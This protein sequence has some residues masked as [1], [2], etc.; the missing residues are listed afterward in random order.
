M[1]IEVI[2][3]EGLKRELTIE[4]PA[5]V[6]DKTY[7]KI[8]DDF[9]R[10]AKIKGFRPGKVPINV[11]R[12]RFKNEVT[13]ELIEQL[14]GQYYDKAVQEK[15]LQP[16]GD[17]VLSSVDVDEGKPFKFTVGIEV[18][19]QIDVVKYEKL[20]IDKGETEV[21]DN[22][23]DHILEHLRKSRGEI[24][25]VER[26]AKAG[27]IL[28]GDLDA[29]AGDVDILDVKSVQNQEIDLGGEYTHKGFKD[30]LVGIKRDE[31]REITIEYPAD[32]HNAKFAGKKVTYRVVVKEVKERILAPLDDAFAKQIGQ[33]ETLLELRLNIRKQ[34]EVDRRSDHMRSNKKKIV[35]QIVEQNAIEVPEGMLDSYL[36]NVINDLKQNAKD[37]NEEEARKQYSPVGMS[38]IRWFLLFHHLA[39]QEKIEVSTEDTENWIKRFADNYQ[40]EV[41]KAKE[42]LSKTGK[43]AEI[44]DG[45]LEDKVLEFLMSK[46]ETK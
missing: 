8:Y 36:R 18:L 37:L 27:D 11:I 31:T 10:K 28:I 41:P 17:P 29:V 5:E 42:L 22:D 15:N 35:D 6:V 19:P 24:R 34:L 30:G 16:V 4:V 1:N 13:A 12:S 38:A 43:V 25:S 7:E 9:R 14:V 44:R 40:M 3:K 45:I 26:A 23:V 32:A 21:P 46:A 39:K 33:G 2:E 20:V